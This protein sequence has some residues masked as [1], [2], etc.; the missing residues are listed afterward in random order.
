MYYLKTIR[1]DAS[2]AYSVGAQGYA[3]RSDEHQRVF[4]HAVCPMNPEKSDLACKLLNEGL[5]DMT[6]SVDADNLK[7]VKELELKQADENVKTNGYWMGKITTYLRYGIDTHTDYKKTVEA[8][9]PQSI[10]AYV[11]NVLL[12]DGNH[13]EVTMMPE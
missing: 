9:T 12:K 10:S 8:L 1:E 5:A 6:K 2:A 4:M 11:K 7:K 3:N 13:I